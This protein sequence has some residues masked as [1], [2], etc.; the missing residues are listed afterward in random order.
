[1][2][3][4]NN[5]NI[6]DWNF[7]DSNIIKVYY[8]DAVCYYKIASSGGTQVPCYAVVDDISQY[9]DTEFEDVFNKADGKWYKLNNL[10]AYEEYGVYGSGRTI[11]Y[12]EGKLTIDDGY[13][14]QY[15]GGSWVNVG[16]VSGTTA[17][18]P[19]VPFV[20]NY[21]A[22]N[23][24]A[25][26]HSIPM[27]TG[28]L[29]DTDAVA[30]NNPNNIVDHHEDGYI[31]ISSS[32]MRIRKVGQD[33][34]L[35]NRQSNSSSSELTIVSKAKTATNGTFSVMTNRDSNYNWMY[36]QYGDHLTLH[37]TSETGQ[38]SCSDTDP[39]ILSVRTYYENGT[40]VKYNNWTQNT[41]TSPQS[42]SYG[43]TNNDDSSAGSLFVGYAWNDGNEQWSGDFYWIYMAQANLTDDQV[44]QVI[45]Y[46]E[47][48]SQ[49]DYPV[50]YDE[51]QDPPNNLSFSSMTEAESYECPWVGM[52]A[53]I[54]GSAYTFNAN[55]EWEELHNYWNI[56]TTEWEESGAYGNLPSSG[57]SV[58]QS[59]SNYHISNS[60]ATTYITIFG[61]E[62]FDFKI[63][64]Y[65]ESCCDYVQV[66]DID[67]ESNIKVSDSNNAQA[68]QWRD[69]SFSGIST[70]VEHT[71]K[72]IYKKDGSVDSNDD[73][74]FI[75]IHHQIVATST[76]V[77]QGE[78]ICSQGDKYQ[79]LEVLAQYEGSSEWVHTGQYIK[80]DL[81]ESGSSDCDS[82]LP[83]GYTKVQ[84]IENPEGSAKYTIL[85][86]YP[87]QDTRYV[88]DLQAH[89]NC[90]S[91]PRMFGVGNYSDFGYLINIECS[92]GGSYNLK[93]GNS[94]GWYSTST[95]VNTNR[96][97]FDFNKGVFYL[98]NALV[99]TCPAKTFT[100]PIKTGVFCS[101]QNSSL[102]V[103]TGEMLRGKI[104]SFDI[105]DNDVLSVSLVP[106]VRDI[107]SV[108]GFYDIVNDVFYTSLN[109]GNF[110]AG[111]VVN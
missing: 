35:F 68:L 65:G 20:L 61:Y 78:Y 90:G 38:I 102:A 13:E 96:H 82:R 97:V 89:Q 52:R 100:S 24:D 72:V 46:N 45:A 16:E 107:D 105:Y 71:I 99:Y 104:Y 47:G 51:M 31:T 36:R 25:T 88:V 80:G 49:P 22:K 93:Y 76:T 23:Y 57:Y 103:D 6:I 77:V 54:A 37:G 39:N 64:S 7:D 91:C 58:Y 73:R 94:G 9:S 108:A 10:N 67:S 101:P 59:F 30:Y 55:Y 1:M 63:R 92:I 79:K 34:S 5:S 32:S 18:L 44:Q 2:I 86:H 11:T 87:T 60:T 50:Y 106:C 14:Y 81:I 98:D 109:D 19:N 15:S 70:N 48:G 8:H 41:S 42:F 111:P 3:K 75:A 110:V 95:S 40:L 33:I 17:T 56:T 28:Q 43:S 66:Y 26:T 53:T 83:D 69:V 29:N 12:Y 85:N 84:Y 21:N 74:G 62:T 27:T 4:F